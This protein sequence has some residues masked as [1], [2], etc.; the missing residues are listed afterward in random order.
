MATDTK[1]VVDARERHWPRQ[2]ER[3]STEYVNFGLTAGVQ[4]QIYT[5]STTGQSCT[6]AELHPTHAKNALAKILRELEAGK[7]AYMAADGTVKYV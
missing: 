2:V 5:S 3:V 4:G 1:Q 7:M 6:I